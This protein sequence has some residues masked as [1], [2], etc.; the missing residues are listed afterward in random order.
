MLD[1]WAM[2]DTVVSASH[3]NSFCTTN[4]LQLSQSACV[5]EARDIVLLCFLVI[6]ILC[7]TL[8]FA[9]LWR[10]IDTATGEWPQTHL[11]PLQ[12]QERPRSPDQHGLSSTVTIP[13]P[14]WTFKGAFKDLESQA[15]FSCRTADS[16]IQTDYIRETRRT[17]DNCKQQQGVSLL[18]SGHF[19]MWGWPP[20]LIIVLDW[21]FQINR[22]HTGGY[23]ISEKPSLGQTEGQHQERM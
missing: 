6:H 11:K 23:F 1:T 17:R 7:S 15:K 10:R 22:A 2:C 12:D 4:T 21:Q 20:P 18:V 13:Q 16:D 8:W 5:S 19:L 9:S 14:C 3:G